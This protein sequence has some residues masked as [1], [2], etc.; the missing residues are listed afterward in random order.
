M[1]DRIHN[2]FSGSTRAQNDENDLFSAIG[3]QV[4]GMKLDEEPDEDE[5]VKIVEEIES[6][7]MSCEENVSLKSLRPMHILSQAGYNSIA[8]NQDSILS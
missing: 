1:E 8:S 4:L 3:K 6:L 2:E 7:C 5:R